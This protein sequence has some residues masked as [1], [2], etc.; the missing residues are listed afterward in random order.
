MVDPMGGLQSEALMIDF[1][2][3]LMLQFR[4]STIISDAGLL[5]YRELDDALHVT[6]TAAATARAGMTSAVPSASGNQRR[7]MP[8]YR[9]I[10]RA[11]AL[12]RFSRR[13]RSPSARGD[14]D[15]PLPKPVRSAMLA[16]KPLLSGECR[17]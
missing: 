7:G 2:R 1:D 10:G 13:P 5:A 6:D 8:R 4:G 16:A 3:R 9:Q 11:S 14:G 15:L 12:K 17:L